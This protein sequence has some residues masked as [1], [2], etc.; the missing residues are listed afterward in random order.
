M[1]QKSSRHFIIFW[2]KRKT[3]PEFRN[4]II[5]SRILTWNSTSCLEAIRKYI[6][7][8]TKDGWYKNSLKI[9]TFLTRYQ[10][11]NDEEKL[12]TFLLLGKSNQ[13]FWSYLLYVFL[14]ISMFFV[15]LI[16]GGVFS[17]IFLTSYMLFF[18]FSI[19][20]WGEWTENEFFH[21]CVQMESPKK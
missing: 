18:V 3:F 10:K 4:I 19:W 21:I 13:T 9:G 11:E 12:D 20:W 1:S 2:K 6:Y 14:F 5:K 7:F 15:C 8:A 17:F 16:R